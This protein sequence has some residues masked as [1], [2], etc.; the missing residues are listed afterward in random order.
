ME[1]GINMKTTFLALLLAMTLLISGGGYTA[2]GKSN[3]ANT[4]T[5]SDRAFL[6]KLE[7]IFVKEKQ[8]TDKVQMGNLSAY[9]KELVKKIAERHPQYT[10]ITNLGQVSYPLTD[11]SEWERGA[12]AVSAKH[13]LLKVQEDKDF[14]YGVSV[15]SVF[16]APSDVIPSHVSK[17]LIQVKPVEGAELRALL[18]SLQEK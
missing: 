14:Y 13:Y 2:Y 9:Q 17:I 6:K 8:K 7:K 11:C 10:Q 3:P 18:K 1:R 4:T 12:T 16:Q 5:T 15:I